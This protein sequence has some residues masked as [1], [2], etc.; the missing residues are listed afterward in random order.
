MHILEVAT[1]TPSLLPLIRDE[2]AA[3]DYV[4]REVAVEVQL[5]TIPKYFVETA[6][7]SLSTM[8][9][10]SRLSITDVLQRL[11]SSDLSQ[12]TAEGSSDDDLGMDNDDDYESDSSAEGIDNTMTD[13]T[14]MIKQ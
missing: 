10:S 8:A 13:T 7:C 12:G 4:I 2:E 5:P 9:R 14:T 1:P 11:D 3:V 6:K